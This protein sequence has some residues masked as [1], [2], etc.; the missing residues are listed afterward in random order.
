[1]EL[2]M[3]YT[4]I[5]IVL[6]IVV[7]GYLIKTATKLAI[8]IIAI[9]VLFGAGFIWGPNDFNEKLGLN[10]ILKPEYSEKVDNFIDTFDKKRDENSVIDQDKLE[11]VY[12]NSKE[13][14]K[15][16]SENWTAKGKEKFSNWFQSAK[17][18]SS[19]ELDELH[20]EIK[21]E[22]HNQVEQE[23]Q[24]Q[25]QGDVSDSIEP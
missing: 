22:I 9:I 4:C 23:V 21:N 3:T 11:E 16:Q 20:N 24:K 2:N 1:M 19:E 14:I 18:K 8:A 12:N 13:N 7:I 6:A 17:E 5:L 25:L 15:V 10:K